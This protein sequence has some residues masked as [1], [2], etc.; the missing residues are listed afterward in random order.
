[1]VVHAGVHA[2]D[3]WVAMKLPFTTTALPN[4]EI[5]DSG[6]GQK[7]G[8]KCGASNLHDAVQCHHTL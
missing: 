5:F 6:N 3:V 8:T 7:G 1:M 2:V 4:S